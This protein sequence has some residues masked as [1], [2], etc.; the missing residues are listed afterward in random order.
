MAINIQNLIDAVN[1][2]Y[3]AMDSATPI[4]EITKL[5]T[6]KEEID[7][8]IGVLS[9]NGLNALPIADS[10][11]AGNIVFIEDTK[12]TDKLGTFYFSSGSEWR[13]L[14]I[15]ADSDED[16]VSFKTEFPGTIAGYVVGGFESPSIP[17]SSKIQKFLFTSDTNASNIGNSSVAQYEGAHITSVN[18][19]YRS[20][21]FPG[22]VGIDKFPFSTEVASALSIT[23]VGQYGAGYSSY[24]DGYAVKGPSGGIEKFPFALEDAVS[25]IGVIGASLWSMDHGANQSW[26]YNTG[27]ITG[28]TPGQSVFSKFLFSSEFNITLLQTLTQGRYD[29]ASQS[30]FTHGYSSG[31][32]GGGYPLGIPFIEKFAFAN[33]STWSNVGDLAV[34][35]FYSGGLSSELS[36]YH[37]GGFP[38]GG[39]D[40]QKFPF[41]SDNNA[42]IIGNTTVNTRNIRNGFQQ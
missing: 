12:L 31:G 3:A 39:T 5:I 11:N 13:K 35:N 27:W 23:G 2:K 10:A 8:S 36:G 4:G 7:A 22:V 17:T 19:G 26:P 33:E 21:G 37:V 30:S 29:H 1:A 40:I 18:A 9:Y 6:A 14:N 15:S 25:T 24:I 28:G 41:E 38:L 32:R 16:Q 20:G 42:S 34:A